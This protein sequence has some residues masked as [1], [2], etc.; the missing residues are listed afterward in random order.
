MKLSNAVTFLPL[1]RPGQMSKMVFV[2]LDRWR[3]GG[4]DPYQVAVFELHEL[5]GTLV[6]VHRVVVGDNAPAIHG[7]LGF[8]QNEMPMP[9]TT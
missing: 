6:F 3:K 7:S 2:G 1:Q 8:C 4:Q 5:L 9:T